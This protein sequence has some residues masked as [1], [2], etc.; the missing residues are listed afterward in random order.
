MPKTSLSRDVVSPSTWDQLIA[1]HTEA[2]HRLQ[3]AS[4]AAAKGAPALEE[5]AD[6]VLQELERL[7]RHALGWPAQDPIAFR[8]KLALWGDGRVEGHEEEWRV[9]VDDCERLLLASQR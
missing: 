5:E 8:F 2:A 6:T 9:F 4:T 3:L 7:E 1:A